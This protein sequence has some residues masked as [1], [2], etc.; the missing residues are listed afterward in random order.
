MDLLEIVVAGDLTEFITLV[1]LLIRMIVTIIILDV[2]DVWLLLRKY[3][4]LTE[5]IEFLW[6]LSIC[7]LAQDLIFKTELL[8]LLL[9]EIV[10]D[11]LFLVWDLGL[12]RVVRADQIRP[13]IALLFLHL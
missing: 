10:Q 13:R 7:L 3:I 1:A 11:L 9:L 4:L 2:G 6:P 8:L 5:R 12:G